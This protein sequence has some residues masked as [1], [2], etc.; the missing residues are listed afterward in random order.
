MFGAYAAVE[1]AVLNGLGSWVFNSLAVVSELLR[2]HV[3]VVIGPVK[4]LECAVFGAFF[5]DEDFAV[6]LENRSVQCL[7][8]FRADAPC[9]LNFFH[10]LHY[11]R[12]GL[13]TV[14][15]IIRFPNV[16]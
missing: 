16:S 8:A 2:S 6:F 1:R 13:R 9:A 11:A 14:E 7:E 15:H 5:F 4:F 12:K 10:A 3:L